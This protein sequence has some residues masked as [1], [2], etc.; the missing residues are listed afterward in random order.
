MRT[1]LFTGVMAVLATAASTVAWA[2]APR[3]DFA[4]AF[5]QSFNDPSTSG[6]GSDHAFGVDGSYALTDR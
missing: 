6:L 5:Y 4:E 1:K 2:D 3:Y